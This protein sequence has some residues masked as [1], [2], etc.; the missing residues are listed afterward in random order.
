L[1]KKNFTP[2]NSILPP[3]NFG[4]YKMNFLKLR[5]LFTE[6]FRYRKTGVS[7]AY[8][9]KNP[10]KKVNVFRILKETVLRA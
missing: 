4:K 7:T 3:Q 8:F 1:T 6:D 10:K 5:F 9:A 2:K